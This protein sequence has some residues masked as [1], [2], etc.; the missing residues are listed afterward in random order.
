MLNNLVKESDVELLWIVGH[1]RVEG[2][3]KTDN[4]ARLEQSSYFRRK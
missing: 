2:N 1:I 4:L 3:V